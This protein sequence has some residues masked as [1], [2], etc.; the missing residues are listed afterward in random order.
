MVRVLRDFRRRRISPATRQRKAAVKRSSSGCQALVTFPERWLAGK[1]R[2]TR[3][4]RLHSRP[5]TTAEGCWP[6]KHRL[7]LPGTTSWDV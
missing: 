4:S 1:Y 2:Q 7:E 3:P 5:T 6:W